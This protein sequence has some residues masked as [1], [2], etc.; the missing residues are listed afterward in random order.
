KWKTA[1]EKEK[2]FRITQA[3]LHA[4]SLRRNAQAQKALTLANSIAEAVALARDLV[5]ESPHVMTPTALASAAQKMAKEVGG[6]T[7]TVHDRKKLEQL[8]MGMFLAVA[9]GSRNDP[10]MIEIRYT[11]KGATA[12]KAKPLAFVGKAIT[13]D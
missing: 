10:R 12:A 6:L 9:Q 8:K 11:P 13:F 7:V 3:S 4:E 5:N 1:D 2:G